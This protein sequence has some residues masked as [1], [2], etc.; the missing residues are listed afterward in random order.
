MKISSSFSEEVYHYY[1]TSDTFGTPIEESYYSE[2]SKKNTVGNCIV[3]AVLPKNIQDKK[4]ANDNDKE[5]Q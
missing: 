3:C 2:P 1:C 4:L 5:N